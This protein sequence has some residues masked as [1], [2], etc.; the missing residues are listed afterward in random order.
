[1]KIDWLIDLRQ[2]TAV[3]P[4]FA[5][6]MDPIVWE[7]AMARDKRTRRGRAT[8]SQEI[9]ERKE[10]TGRIAR[11]GLKP[12]RLDQHEG[13]ILNEIRANCPSCADPGRCE[14][15][16]KLPQAPGWE[17]WDE[18]CPN[19]ARLRVLAAFSLYPRDGD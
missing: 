13:R 1:V 9:P 15:E 17:D 10:L 19:A 4:G 3:L 16:L 7:D 5:F 18:Y 2:C 6:I 11:I 12:E 14:A 8:E